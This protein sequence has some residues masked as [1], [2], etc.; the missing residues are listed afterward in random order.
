[1]KRLFARPRSLLLVAVLAVVAAMCTVP[2]AHAA[3]SASES[4]V[5]A[6]P[7]NL[8]ATAVSP[9]SVRLTWTNNAANQSGVVISLDGVDS[10]DVQGATVSSY[11]GDGLSPGTKYWFYIASKI[12]GTPGD[13]TGSGNTQSAWVGPVYVTTPNTSGSTDWADSSFCSRYSVPYI[14]ITYRGVA[15]CGDPF[16]NG[17]NNQQGTITYNGKTLDTIGFQCAELAARYFYFDTGQVP[18]Q[19]GSANFPSNASQFAYDLQS[20]GYGLYPT[21][22]MVGT[23]TFQSSLKAGNIISMWS[24]SDK[25]GHVA[26]VTQVDVAS[27]GGTI[28][29][30][31]ENASN[32]V[33]GKPGNGKIT[34]KGDMSMS[35]EGLYNEFQWTTSLP[36]SG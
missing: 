14:G 22:S 8:T 21:G 13:P 11:T 25:V 34:V 2:T 9:D 27:G 29:V 36:G 30:M 20:Y 5:P 12:Y 31:D 35:Y 6:A 7:S 26:V 4:V 32:L 19:P 28:W 3:S 24:A 23:S 33:P 1:M 17:N 16:G 10:V 15:A 18:P